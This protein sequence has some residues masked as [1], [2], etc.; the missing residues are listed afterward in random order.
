M[1][2]AAREY[3]REEEGGWTLRALPN[4]LYVGLTRVGAAA[5]VSVL[6]CPERM[7]NGRAVV[8]NCVNRTLLA[9]AT[10]RAPARAEYSP[11]ETFLEHVRGDAP[12]RASGRGSKSGKE[13]PVAR[14]PP[15][16]GKRRRKAPRERRD[17]DDDFA[18][19]IA[20][21]L[22]A[23]H[24][25]ST[26][27]ALGRLRDGLARRVEA[28]G[29]RVVDVPGDGNCQFH[30]LARQLAKKYGVIRTHAQI[31]QKCVDQLVRD[32]ALPI[33]DAVG[34]TSGHAV[35]L[36]TLE[37]FVGTPADFDTYTQKM[38]GNM[39]GDHFTLYAAAAVFRARIK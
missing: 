15:A 37:G 38:R 32:R 8:I 11:P 31:R 29:L 25:C 16:G 35:D 1:G 12:S 7:L 24:Y 5:D 27:K 18:L 6:V 30:A 3:R 23:A 39:W 22:S 14:S 36:G 21:F 4:Q 28:A 13:S 10:E 17:A 26:T 19:L 33:G 2:N 34:H 20:K 9:R